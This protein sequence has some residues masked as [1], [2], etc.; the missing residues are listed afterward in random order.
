MSAH[1]GAIFVGYTLRLINKNANYR[2]IVG[3]GDFDV[4]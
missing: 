4:N 2:L 1:L 3:A